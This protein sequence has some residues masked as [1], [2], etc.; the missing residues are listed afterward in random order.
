LSKKPVFRGGFAY[1][2]HRSW[3]VF[4]KKW[5]FASYRASPG[6]T[7]YP[8]FGP[9]EKEILL[10]R[11]QAPRPQGAGMGRRWRRRSFDCERE[12]FLASGAGRRVNRKEYPPRMQFMRVAWNP[13]ASALAST[14]ASWPNRHSTPSSQWILPATMMGSGCCVAFMTFQRLFFGLGPWVQIQP[15]YIGG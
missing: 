1:L 7:P 11:G 6:A 9:P 12:A 14:A 3:L 8:H 5:K 10:N 2:D 4:M 13:A 15:L